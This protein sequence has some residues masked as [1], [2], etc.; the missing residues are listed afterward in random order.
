MNAIEEIAAERKRQIEQEGWS[1]AH[2]A[3]HWNG[4][5]A[6]AAACYAIEAASIGKTSPEEDIFL[7]RL[8][9]WERKWWKPKDAR[10]DLVRA[11]ALI[12]A[13]IDR[14]D[15]ANQQTAEPAK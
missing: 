10:R 2:D 8:W 12:V 15:H 11:G 5:L 13:E 6:R 3:A 14:L 7:E 4:D 1:A 9:P